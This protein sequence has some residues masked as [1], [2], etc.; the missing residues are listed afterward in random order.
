M[1]NAIDRD[2]LFKVELAGVRQREVEKQVAVLAHDVC[3]QI[4]DLLGG[5]VLLAALVVPLADAGIG[6]PGVRGD[7]VCNTALVIESAGSNGTV[8][9]FLAV[10]DSLSDAAMQARAHV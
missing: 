3:E 7:S 9:G 2:P 6:L 8:D 10:V 1:G 5:L 4:D